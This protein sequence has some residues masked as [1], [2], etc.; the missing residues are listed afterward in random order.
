MKTKTRNKLIG[1]VA[2]VF[3]ASCCAVGVSQLSARDSKAAMAA[4]TEP[5]I[6]IEFKNVSYDSS[7]RILYAV[8][9]EGF[10]RQQ[11]PI[12]MLFWDEAQDEYTLGTQDYTASTSGYTTVEGKNCLVFDSQGIAAKEMR[13]SIYA[14]AYAE[15]DGETYYSDTIEYSVEQYVDEL[16]EKD[17]VT[18]DKKALATAMLAYGDAAKVLLGGGN[19]GSGNDSTLPEDQPETTGPSITIYKKNVSYSSYTHI[20]YAVGNQGFD[21]SENPIQMLF[22]NEPQ[23]EYVVGTQSYSV[24]NSGTV[25]LGGKDC[26]VFYSNGLAAKK[27]TDDVYARAYAVVDGVTYYSEVVK[28]SVLEYAYQMREREN[29]VTDAEKNLFDALLNYGAAAQVVF[30]YNTHKPANAEYH[31]VSIGG[32]ALVDGMDAGRFLLGQEV[33]IQAKPAPEGEQFAYWTDANG[34]VVDTKETLT[35][36]VTGN[37]SYTAVYMPV[38]RPTYTVTFNTDG[39][40]A[41]EAQTVKEGDFVTEP[42]EQPTKA[43]Y[44]FEGWDYD[45][46]T[47]I[48]ENVEI[49]AIWAAGTATYRVEHYWENVNDNGYTLHEFYEFEGQTGAMATADALAYE[50]FTYNEGASTLSG[51]IAG[52]GSLVLSVYYTRDTYYIKTRVKSDETDTVAGTVS[53]GGT[54]KYGKQITLKATTKTDTTYTFGGWYDG[55]ILVCEAEEFTFTVEQEITYTARWFGAN[56][57]YAVTYRLETLAGEYP[58]YESEKFSYPSGMPTPDP[59]IREYEHFTFDYYN[60]V[61]DT[62]RSTGKTSTKIY[63]TRNSYTITSVSNNEAYGSVSAGGTY[64]YETQLTLTATPNEGYTFAG[65]YDGDTLVSNAAEFTFTVDKNV[66]YTAKF[67]ELPAE[68]TINYY[69]QNADDDGYTQFYTFT[70]TGVVGTMVTV[71]VPELGVLI[72]NESMSTISGVILRDGSLVLSIYYD[73]ILYTIETVCDNE[74][75]G[76]VSGGGEYKIEQTITL[77]A[78]TNAGY[79]FLGWYDGGTLVGATEVVTLQADKDA[80]YTAK[81]S[82]NT[83]TEYKVRYY[84]QDLDGVYSLHEKFT[85]YGTT[86]EE[87]SAEIKTYEHFTY[88]PNKSRTSGVIAGDGSLVL[89]VAYTRNSYTV[90]TVCGNAKAGTVS[91][92]GTYKYGAEITLTATTNTG[93]IF[94]GWFDGDT[95]VSTEEVCTVTVAKNTIYTAVWSAK[96][97]SPY[98]VEYYLQN[99]DGGYTLY[100]TAHLKG[101]P[102]ITVT[103]TIRE[104]SYYEYDEQTSADTISGKIAGDGSLVLKVY[105]AYKGAVLDFE[106][107]G[108]GSYKV[109]GI[110]HHTDGVLTIPEE[111]QGKPVTTIGAEAFYNVRG[112]GKLVIPDCVTTIEDYAFASCLDLTE[113]EMGNGVTSIGKYAFA[114]CNQIDTLTMSTKVETIDECA[115]YGCKRMRT[116]VLPDTLT[117]IAKEAFKE[118]KKLESITFGSGLTTIGEAAFY[119]CESLLELNLNAPTTIGNRAFMN[120]S[121]LRKVTLGNKVQS[122]GDEAFC[123]DA[124]GDGIKIGELSIGNGVTKI[125]ASAFQGLRKLY[126]VT[127]GQGL[128]SIGENAFYK[129]YVLREVHNRSSLPISTNSGKNYGYV[130]N[131]AF[132]VYKSVTSTRITK[133]DNGLVYYTE[134]SAKKLISITFD[135]P[136]DL[137]IPNDVTEIS[138]YACYNEQYIT[139]VIIG[140]NSNCTTIGAHAFQNDYNMR[141][142]DLSGKKLTTLEDNAF[143]NN[144]EVCHV[145]IGT[146]LKTVGKG[147]FYKKG[148]TSVD[149]F[150]YY[151]VFYKGTQ[152]KWQAFI[153]SSNFVQDNNEH[154]KGALSAVG[155]DTAKYSTVAFYTTSTPSS[156]TTTLYWRYVNGQET[157]WS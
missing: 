157:Y 74:K 129:C 152:A 127:L 72:Y 41:V 136:Q 115:F 106:L 80:T 69:W 118:C 148:D 40:T 108:D 2:S 54:Y 39:G 44:T 121:N 112:I 140:E 95:R 25:T 151:R 43:G 97:D 49:K 105:Y 131:Y 119:R 55:V 141:R 96:T 48:T 133:D 63:Y 27:M 51:E 138:P 47:P 28:Y 9:N 50:H 101:E 60:K 37:E 123:N 125:G 46:S 82:A 35:F 12:Q 61:H 90:T 32:G 56:V 102:G 20:L 1:V 73:R 38:E 15:V 52:D 137:I 149:G 85:L 5:S 128:T 77:I 36:T 79:T 29:G 153:T 58:A 59:E 99:D 16:Y 18:E 103:A 93:Y 124:D 111:Y 31:K 120:C 89:L 117:T 114:Y 150:K 88:N 4:T 3:L 64:K 66:T 19:S 53:G 130:A 17:G 68:Y 65:W 155:T 24:E 70:E 87:I 104:Y 116:L 83:N 91:T 76:T 42:T 86:D 144:Q 10:D 22:W 30:N 13:D 154:L 23:T 132:Y 92:G 78:T 107:M 145:I 139:G 8:S 67:T 98:T 110:G 94:D 109:V 57:K 33:T 122:I 21:R 84:W 156:S 147:A 45:F 143:F 14:R 7:L 100:E 81:W 26:L 71:E 6:T 62:I 75:A 11:N 134:G 135:K 113:V 126:K 146:S 34:S 142:L